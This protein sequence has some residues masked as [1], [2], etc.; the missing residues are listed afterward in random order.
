MI[1]VVEVDNKSSLPD[2]LIAAH[3]DIKPGEPL[4]MPDLKKNIDR[5]YGIDTFER[6]D[7]HV[8]KKTSPRRLSS[9]LSIRHGGRIISGSALAWRTTSRDPAVTP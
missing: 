9:N 8:R 2:A 7:F 6:V 1:D 5:V 3:V 4:S